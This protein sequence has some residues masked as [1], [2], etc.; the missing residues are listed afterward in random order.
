[1]KRVSSTHALTV[2]DAL[3]KLRC[4]SS[5]PLLFLRS[6]RANSTS[7]GSTYSQLDK[8]FHCGGNYSPKGSSFLLLKGEFLAAEGGRSGGEDF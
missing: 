5:V 3:S 8:F 1:M 6:E 2:L 4:K 7:K